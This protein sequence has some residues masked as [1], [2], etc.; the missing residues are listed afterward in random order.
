[1]GP[2]Q[3]GGSAVAPNWACLPHLPR[4][5]LL[6]CPGQAVAGTPIHQGLSKA[7][8]GEAWIRHLAHAVLLP[9][10][11]MLCPLQMLST[12]DRKLQSSHSMPFYRC[13][14]LLPQLLTMKISWKKAKRCPEG[15]A[16]KCGRINPAAKGKV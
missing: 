1:M 14:L 7:E 13:M 4:W 8:E 12:G 15:R 9:S 6:H 2:Q 5:P 11:R 10:H 3:G 16:E